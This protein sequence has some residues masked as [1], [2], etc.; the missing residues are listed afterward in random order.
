MSRYNDTITLLSSAEPYQDAGGSWHE[1][2]R[3]ENTVFCNRYSLSLS[4][5]STAL[6]MGLRA[7]AQVQVRAVDYNG[8]DQCYYP[9]RTSEDEDMSGK[10]LDVTYSTQGGDFV[11]LTLGRKLGN[12]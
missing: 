4:A 1:G 12:K 10:E 11:T 7:T 9:A 2:E 8:E 3:T 5:S 6:D